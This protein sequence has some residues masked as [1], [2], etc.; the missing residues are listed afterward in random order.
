MP[1]GDAAHW[2]RRVT[3]MSLAES[4]RFVVPV[5]FG[6]ATL[7]MLLAASGFLGVQFWHDWQAASQ[8]VEH[9]RQV[10]DAIDE[11]RGSFIDLNGQ[12]RSRLLAQDPDLLNPYPVPEDSVRQEIEA[13]ETLVAKDPLQNL[14]IAHLALIL[15]ATLRPMDDLLTMARTSGLEAA[16]AILRSNREEVQSQIDQMEYSERLLLG[17][18]DV[19]Q[20]RAGRLIA[21]AV[22]IAIISAGGAL[23]LAL[24]EV[25]RGW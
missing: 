13:L 10:I 7:L 14:R 16:L 4:R 24:V 17:R 8:Q 25:G 22:A 20:Q 15:E 6:I 12:R 11:V 9:S 21:L 23:A 1:A 2:A 5:I 18:A 3:P 19:L